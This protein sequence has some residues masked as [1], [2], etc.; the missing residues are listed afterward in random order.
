[1][2]IGTLQLR[3]NSALARIRNVIA[4]AD[5]QQS[6]DARKFKQYSWGRYDTEIYGGRCGYIRYQ[7]ERKGDSLSFRKND[8]YRCTWCIRIT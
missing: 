6:V 4:T 2:S 3:F 8:L 7:N 1:V 5:L